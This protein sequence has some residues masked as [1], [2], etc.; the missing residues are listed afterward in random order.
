MLNKSHGSWRA[1]SAGTSASI[2]AK[3]AVG[4]IVPIRRPVTSVWPVV[5]GEGATTTTE[6][7]SSRRSWSV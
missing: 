7:A 2:V 6:S 3:P 4:P 1:G 5:S